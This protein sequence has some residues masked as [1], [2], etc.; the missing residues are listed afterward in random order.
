M[1]VPIFAVI[2]MLT[3]ASAIMAHRKGADPLLCGLL[4]F[5]VPWYGPF[6]VMGL[7]TGRR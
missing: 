7:A 2:L 6:F 4:A 5:F 3:V 1:L